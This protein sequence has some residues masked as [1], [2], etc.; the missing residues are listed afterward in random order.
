MPEKLNLAWKARKR[1][2]GIWRKPG[3]KLS[4]G[5]RGEKNKKRKEKSLTVGWGGV[6]EASFLVC[7][8]VW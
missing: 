8:C 1:V 3:E 6:M 2:R 5:M 7:V 4:K